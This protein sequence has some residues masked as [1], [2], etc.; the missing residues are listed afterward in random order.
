MAGGIRREAADRIYDRLSFSPVDRL[1]ES[2][3]FCKIKRMPPAME[4]WTF[5]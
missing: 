4:K 2:L 1:K 5:R 3:V